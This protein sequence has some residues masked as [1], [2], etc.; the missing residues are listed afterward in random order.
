MIELGHGGRQISLVGTWGIGRKLDVCAYR[1][2]NA[3]IGYQRIFMRRTLFLLEELSDGDLRA[4]GKWHG[5]GFKENKDLENC[6]VRKP[7]TNTSK[8]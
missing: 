8:I 3:G 6:G 2:L 5:K 7:T 1:S 4:G